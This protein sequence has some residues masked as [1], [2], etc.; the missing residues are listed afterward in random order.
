[1][2]TSYPILSKVENPSDLKELSLSELRKLCQDIREYIIQTVSQTGGHLASNLGTVEL[3]VALHRVFN[4]PKDKIVWDVGH[5][6]YPHKILTGRRDLMPTLRQHGGISG[7]PNP[8][9]SE[10]DTFSVGHASTSIAAAMGIAKARDLR[11][12]SFHVIAVI[13]DGAMTGGLA[14]EA[15]NNAANLPSRLIVILNDNKMSISP[16]VGGMSRHLSYLR[17]RPT[18][19][20]VKAGV[21]KTIRKV[22]L[23]GKKLAKGLDSASENIFYFVTPSRTGILFEEFGFTYLGPFDGHNLKVLLDIFNAAKNWSDDEPILIHVLTI[24]GRGFDPAEGSP[25]SYHGVGTFNP[26]LVKVEKV[27]EKAPNDSRVSYTDVFSDALLEL[28]I[29]NPKIVAITAAMAEGTGLDKF[30]ERI[31]ERF[32]DVGIAEQ[33]AVTFAGGLATRGMKPVCAIYSTFLQRAFDQCIHDIGLQKLPV[34]FA[35]DRGGLV[36]ADG[37][38]HHGAFDLSYLRLIPNFVVMAPKD[39]AELRDML[40]TALEHDG[41]IALRYP[42]GKGEGVNLHKGFEKI[43][44]GKGEILRQGEDITL[45]GIGN[46]VYRCLEAAENLSKSGINATVINARFVKPID[47]DLILEEIKKTRRVITVEENTLIG[48]FGSAV[49][50]LLAEEGLEYAESE[51]AEDQSGII[52]IKRIGLPDRFI[53]HGSQRKLYAIYGLTSESIYEKARSM[54]GKVLLSVVDGKTREYETTEEKPQAET[55][56]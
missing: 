48:G 47:R 34:V 29:T 52:Q 51:L 3:T 32:F 38:T 31:P 16:N 42:R 30:R 5:Q 37:P 41:P 45:I 49:L 9:E 39:E 21:I 19:R 18:L 2:N 27:P 54:V 26:D 35:L 33:F 13:G 11:G 55:S 43:P 10:Y 28:A 36:G 4:A 23:V 56:G 40:Y 15:I 44:I 14:L 1:M 46:M 50:E 24:K 53:E 7:F 22:P 12:E 25:V 20:A 17:T 8:E 6:A